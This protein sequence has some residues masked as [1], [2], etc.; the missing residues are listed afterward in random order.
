MIYADSSFMVSVYLQ[1]T[2]SSEAIR[3]LNLSPALYVTQLN[4]AEVAHTFHQYVFRGQLDLF[5]VRRAWD[6]FE[7]DCAH[8]VWRRIEMPARSWE[9]SIDLARKHGPVLGI[10]TLDSLHVA[11]ALEVHAQNFWTFDER[12]GR[13][14]AAAGLRVND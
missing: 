6:E 13:L 3:R 5:E 11:A 2:H 14:A 8:G 10:R 7:E 4:R 12:Q 1:D 9:T